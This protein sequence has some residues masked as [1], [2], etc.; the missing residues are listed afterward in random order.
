MIIKFDFLPLL[1]MRQILFILLVFSPGLFAQNT[2][3]VTGIPDTSF[4]NYS[5]WKSALKDDS[6]LQLAELTASQV[7]ATR[8]LVYKKLGQR[9]LVLDVYEPQDKQIRKSVLFFH[10]GGWRTGHRS[11]H[12]MLANALASKGYRVFL[13]EYRL[14]TEALYPAAMLDAQSA[15]IYLHQQSKNLH[16]DSKQIYV[17]GYSAGGQMAALLGSVQDESL[18]GQG[19]KIKGIIDL[20]GILAF[21]HPESGEGDDRV[22]TSAASSYFG[23]TKMENPALWNQASALYHVSKQDPPVLF[24]NSGNDRMHAGRDD[25]RQKMST[26]G[27]LTQVHTFEGSPHTFLLFTKWFN[28]TVQ[29]MDQ[30]M[31]K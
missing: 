2:Q 9:S 20:D 31:L 5:A 10:G 3:G 26:Y 19:Q 12:I 7:K 25:F 27:I 28:Q 18:F 8:T 30:F 17:A 16:V 24:I 4:A 11:Q 23:Y 6:S 15:L 1:N 21:I 13:A 29:L 14:S 22:R